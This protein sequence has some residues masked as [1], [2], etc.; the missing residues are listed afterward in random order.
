MLTGVDPTS[1]RPVYRQ[2]ADALRGAIER[3]ELMTLSGGLETAGAVLADGPVG[4]AGRW[5]AANARRLRVAVGVL[6]AVV[7]L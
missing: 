5:V 6:G 2:I 7:L 1:D 4:G 3:G